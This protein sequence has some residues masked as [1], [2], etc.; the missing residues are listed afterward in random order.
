MSEVLRKIL[1]EGKDIAINSKEVKEGTIFIAMQG[2]EFDGRD[3]INEAIKKGAS[4][5]I[6]EATNFKEKKV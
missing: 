4:A 6:Y 3:Y 2:L 5:I 1:S